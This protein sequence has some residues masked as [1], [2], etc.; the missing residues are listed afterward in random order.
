MIIIIMIIIRKMIIMMIIMSP[1]VALAY[2]PTDN[3]NWPEN[4]LEGGRVNHVFCLF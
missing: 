3:L 4:I 2:S 1:H